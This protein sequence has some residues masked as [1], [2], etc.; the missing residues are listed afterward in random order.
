[1]TSLTPNLSTKVILEIFAPGKIFVA[2]KFKDQHRQQRRQQR[3]Q[4][5]QQHRQRRQ[6]RRQ[7][8]HQRHQNSKL[9]ENIF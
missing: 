7:R 9:P 5:R 4:R 1:M 3:G 8:R 6:Q 2:R